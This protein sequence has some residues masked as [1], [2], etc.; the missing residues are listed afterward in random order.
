MPSVPLVCNPIGKLILSYNLLL[1]IQSIFIFQKRASQTE[2]MNLFTKLTDE[3]RNF[4]AANELGHILQVNK[5][6]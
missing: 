3:Y 5:S 6:V 4:T 1:S 2:I